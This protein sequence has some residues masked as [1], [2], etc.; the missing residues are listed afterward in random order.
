MASS[1]N[2]PSPADLRRKSPGPSPRNRSRSYQKCRPLR[3]SGWSSG[4]AQIIS[5]PFIWCSLAQPGIID[6]TSGP[7][8]RGIHRPAHS[9]L[10]RLHRS[11]YPGRAWTDSAHCEQRACAKAVRTQRTKGRGRTWTSFGRCGTKRS[12]VWERLFA[13]PIAQHLQ[14][15]PAGRRL[16]GANGLAVDQQ[17]TE[18]PQL[19]GYGQPGETRPNNHYIVH[20]IPPKHARSDRL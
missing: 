17:H 7:W 13:G 20:A 16:A 9:P 19:A 1:P 18:I 12:C 4:R 14:D 2:A 15:R 11:R 5:I 6:E 8:P 3:L 10:G